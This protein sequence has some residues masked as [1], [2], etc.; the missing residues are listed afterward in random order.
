[1]DVGGVGERIYSDSVNLGGGGTQPPEMKW[2]C[3]TWGDASAVDG[4]LYCLA[5]IQ[6][7]NGAFDSYEECM[8]ATW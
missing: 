2:D 4:T 7:V 6:R 5:C 3:T 1:M 8:A